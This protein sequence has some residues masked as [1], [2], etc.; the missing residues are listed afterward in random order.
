MTFEKIE[1]LYTQEARNYIARF[2][3]STG[4]VHMAEDIVH[5]A[6]E[7]AMRYYDAYDQDQDLK[8]WMALILRNT[9]RDMMRI[10]RGTPTIELDEFEH[11]GAECDGLIR[12]VWREVKEAIDGKSEVHQEIL[13]LHYLKEY[14]VTDISRFTDNTL[15]N[16][17][18]VVSRFRKEMKVKYG[19]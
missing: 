9:Y 10:E 2:A 4:S 11:Q 3:R 15:S 18:Q 5:E 13:T 8:R 14:T 17:A 7:R 12:R 19:W 16:C 1:E 6:F